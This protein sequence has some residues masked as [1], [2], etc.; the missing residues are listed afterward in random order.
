MRMLFNVQSQDP[1]IDWDWSCRLKFRVNRGT[2]PR[3]GRRPPG[4]GRPQLNEQVT[5]AGN[6]SSGRALMRDAEK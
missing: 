6:L 1:R 2:T 5:V 4:P 3:P